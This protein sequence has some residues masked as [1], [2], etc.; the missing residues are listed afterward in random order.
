MNTLWIISANRSFAKIYEAKGH[1]HSI[2]EVQHLDN[3][4]GRKKNSELGSDKPGRSFDRVGGGR[5]ALGTQVD[6]REHELQ[7]FLFKLVHLLDE[8]LKSKSFN[9]LAIVA[10]PHV[11]GALTQELPE[12]L[13]K[14]LIKEVPK[15]LPERIS[16]Q[17][18]ID[19]LCKYLDLW[20]HT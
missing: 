9:Q 10:P 4:D 13:R 2:K 16:D 11:L 3:P 18:R 7:G 1:G 17:E 6:P 12:Q 14:L 15:D 8:G 19:M 20:N 5:H